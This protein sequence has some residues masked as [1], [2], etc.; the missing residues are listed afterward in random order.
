MGSAAMDK[1][2]NIAVGYSVS[3]TAVYPSLRYAGR[4]ATDPL[5]TLPQGE[6]VI[7]NGSFSQTSTTRWGDYSALTVDP[8]DDCTFWYTGEYVETSNGRWGTRIAAFRF[9]TCGG[10]AETIGGSTTGTY[11]TFAVCINQT[12]SQTVPIIL[13]GANAWDCEAAG[14]TASPGDSVRTV[15]GGIAKASGSVGGAVTGLSTTGLL[16]RNLTTTQSVTLPLG[17]ATSWDC[18]SSG[19]NVS[20]G[21]VI[22]MIVAGHAN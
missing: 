3:S 12:T 18:E 17:G 5:G 2:G 14:L 16:C 9:P 22:R 7:L 8:A 6:N 1:D 15:I 19:L 13:G 20:P 10:A 4:L 21:N 11:T